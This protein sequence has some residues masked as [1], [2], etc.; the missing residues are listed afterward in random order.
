MTWTPRETERNWRA[1]ASSADGTK[2]VAAAQDSQL[3]TSQDG[4]DLTFT[5][6][7]D[8]HGS[9]YASFTFQVQDNGGTADGGVD[10]DP[11]PKTMTLD[12]TFPASAI[13]LTGPVKSGSDYV[14]GFNAVVGKSYHIQYTDDLGSNVWKTATPPITAQTEPV[15]WV[16]SGPPATDPAGSSRFYR[17]L[18]AD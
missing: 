3:Y 14:I 15:Q 1:V 2:L 8:G 11:T 12:V 6:A 7:A 18:Q 5:P 10:L 17:V 9:P 4:L 13:A 16:D